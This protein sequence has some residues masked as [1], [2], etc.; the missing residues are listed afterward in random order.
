MTSDFPEGKTQF[1]NI[2]HLTQ[3]SEDL[4]VDP[5]NGDFHFKEGVVFAG[6]GKAG[7]PRWWK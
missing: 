1:F 5:K 2:T 3:S 7:D 4:F 6:K